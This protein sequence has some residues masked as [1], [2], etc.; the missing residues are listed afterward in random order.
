MKT[1][2]RGVLLFAALFAATAT[3]AVPAVNITVK[4]GASGRIVKQARSDSGGTFSLGRLPEG[5]YTLEFRSANSSQAKEMEFS[6]AIDGI[7]KTSQSSVSGGSLIGG[8]TVN[9]EVGPRTNVVGLI[10]V[11][12][13][14]AQRRMIYLPP[15]I[16]SH[17][18]GKW[19]EKG[20]AEAVL[21]RNQGY[22]RIE[23]VQKWQDHGDVGH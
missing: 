20:S 22:V 3:F 5:G 1:I 13:N 9:V 16:G 2:L 23:T 21:P 11:G 19:V 4:Q 7:K 10:L 17:M 18:P 14:A 15:I 12:P 6:I 8:V